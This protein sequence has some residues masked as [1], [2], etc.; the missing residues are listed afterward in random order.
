MQIHLNKTHVLTIVELFYDFVISTLVGLF[1]LHLITKKGLLASKFLGLYFLIFCSRI[2]LAYFI[3]GG[4]LVEY[5][6]L[7]MIGSPIHF[8]APPVAFLYVY[9]ML[10][11][12]HKLK[13]WQGLLFIPFVLHGAEL[14]PFYFGPIE[15][16]LSE[17]NLVMQYKSLVNY[18]G[19]VTFFPPK[20]LSILKVSGTTIYAIASFIL[21]L[22]FIRKN[23]YQRSFVQNWLLAYTSLGL[24]STVFIIAYLLGIIGFNNLRFSYAD[25]LMHL[26]AFLNLGVVLYR[27]SLLDPTIFR[28]LVGRLHPEQR[29]PEPDEDAEKLKKY[30][31]YAQGMEAYF[32][33]ENPFLQGD[34]SLET[35]AKKVGVSTRELSRTTQYIYELNYPDFVN[36]WRINYILAQRKENDSWRGMSQD[37]LAEQAGFGSRQG[38]HNAINKLHG[39]TPAAFFAQKDAEWFLSNF[40]IIRNMLQMGLSNFCYLAYHSKV[41]NDKHRILVPVL[42]GKLPVLAIW[43]KFFVQKR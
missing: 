41:L 30:E 15:N 26:A 29:H 43:F 42:F 4:R 32:A 34:V 1:G 11:P 22:N 33:K 16:K 17:I 38:L 31:Q 28:S 13:V 20:V 24:L 39:M 23:S 12:T 35:T 25:L 14:M 36:S 10:Y 37:M 27:P 9:F 40:C 6:H 18:P 7:F 8:L 21:V 2:I 3:T 5:P 19:T